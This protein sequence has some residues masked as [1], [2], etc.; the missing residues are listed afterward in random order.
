MKLLLLTVVILAISAF[1]FLLPADT[2][3]A[4]VDV[5]VGVTVDTATAIES[6]SNEISTVL[7]NR[8]LR[9]STLGVKVY[10]ISS[11]KD[12]FDYRA[13][14]PVTPAST[15]K[16]LTSSTALSLFGPSYKIRTEIRADN[17][18]HGTVDG[19]I[20]IKGFGDPTFSIHDLDSLVQELRNIG[21]RKV[22]GDV[23]GDGS[24]FDQVYQRVKYSGDPELVEATPPVSALV[25]DRNAVTIIAASGAP[26][27]KVR[28]QTIPHDPNIV[29]VDNAR[30]GG[31][32][33][34][35]HA[36]R[37]KRRSIAEEM[38]SPHIVFASYTIPIRYVHRGRR[39]RIARSLLSFSESYSKTG[40]MVVTVSGR[41]PLG[42]TVSHHVEFRD[43]TL[44]IAA[45]LKA[46]LESEGIEIK[47]DATTGE[48]PLK[49]QVLVKKET[50]LL[51]VL[52]L[53]NKNSDNYAAEQVFKMI[54]AEKCC[55]P[56]M[57]CGLA[58]TSVKYIKAFLTSSHINC[59]QCA[60]HD[61][62]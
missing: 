57:D 15:M 46:R 56:G 58:D 38:Q 22:T 55:V 4:A 53:L 62:S 12:I 52:A 18:S 51:D 19:N 61:G 16:L 10:S 27:E 34:A 41:L 2:S 26:G 44:S 40:K 7:H 13:S 36:R 45:I 24:Y 39:R 9:G 31:A 20:Y 33:H 35:P 43:P 54:G 42:R 14:D 21:L 29:F 60:I 28:L 11:R 50:P 1:G 37:K 48:T 17:F 25:L 49:A 6:L 5:P 32:K 3:H 59:S 47:G 30:T 23:I 8:F